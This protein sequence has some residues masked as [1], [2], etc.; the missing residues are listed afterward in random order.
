MPYTTEELQDVDFYKE[1]I[2]KKRIDYLDRIAKQ[3]L[4]FC[5]LHSTS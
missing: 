2:D 1:F 5:A 3:A 4:N